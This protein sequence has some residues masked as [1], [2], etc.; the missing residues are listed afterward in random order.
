[1]RLPN[2]QLA[3]VGAILLQAITC[4]AMINNDEKPCLYA[5]KSCVVGCPFGY[6][7]AICQQGA[8]NLLRHTGFL[9]KQ[10]MTP[11]MQEALGHIGCSQC[12]VGLCCCVCGLL[13]AEQAFPGAVATRYQKIV[14]L[15]SA[16][17]P[18]TTRLIE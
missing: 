9:S 6:G 14:N 4:S 8:I 17:Q 11:A 3:L 10:A 15:L 5:T 18:E 1:M 13:C 2:S 7:L 16:S 12:R